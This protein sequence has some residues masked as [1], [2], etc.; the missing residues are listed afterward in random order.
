[1]CGS[2]SVVHFEPCG[3][4]WADFFKKSI[5]F[6]VG[7]SGVRLTVRKVPVDSHL[8][9]D[10]SPRIDNAILAGMVGLKIGF[11]LGYYEAI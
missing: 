7:E 9:I 3:S 8:G 1:V 2:L 6:F 4:V 10:V 11:R 5:I